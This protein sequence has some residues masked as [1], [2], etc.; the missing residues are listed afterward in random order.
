MYPTFNK[1]LSR[2]GLQP[3]A[4]SLWP[5]CDH[6]ET[7][8][9]PLCDY[10][11]TTLLPLCDHFATILRLLW[12]HCD[13]FTTTL[14]P[15]CDHFETTLRSLCDRFSTILNTQ[16]HLFATFVASISM[17]LISGRPF[18]SQGVFFSA[19]SLRPFVT[20]LRL[21]ATIYLRGYKVD[22]SRY[23]TDISL[24]LFSFK[25]TN[26]AVFEV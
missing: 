6:F 16:K 21:L 23:L 2:C 1:P 18:C 5:L 14:R 12:D 19:T 9:R 13:H 10:F 11:A 3:V 20:I 7:T 24:K 22:T 25:M 17:A 26:L 8:L 4:T 15:L